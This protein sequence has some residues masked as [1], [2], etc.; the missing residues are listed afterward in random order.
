MSRILSVH[1][2]EDF[3]TNGGEKYGT[4]WVNFNN[5]YKLMVRN[6]NSF[7]VVTHPYGEPVTKCISEIRDDVRDEL[8]EAINSIK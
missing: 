8:I 6:G 7:G 3:E 4:Y 1:I 2:L 5:T